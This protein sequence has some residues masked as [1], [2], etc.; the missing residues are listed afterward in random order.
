MTG[1]AA[2][3]VDAAGLLERAVAYALGNVAVVTPDLLA[4]PTPCRAWDLRMLLWHSCES[5]A[6][7]GEGFADGFVALAAAHDNAL[8]TG[9]AEVFTARACLLLH[10]WSRVT[11][12][13]ILVAGRRLTVSVVA[14]AGALEIAVHG[15][16][17][18]EACGQQRPVPAALALSLLEI[19][20]LLVS[21]ADRE[22]L[23]AAEVAVARE[24]SASDKLTAFLGRTTHGSGEARQGMAGR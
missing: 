18:A 20:P 13:D 16:D 10:T 11:R 15:W 3:S 7:L 9:P 4:R 12:P 14:A 21:G 22:P 2:A 24:A 1:T 17:V 23:F 6:A 19:A 8:R 5:L